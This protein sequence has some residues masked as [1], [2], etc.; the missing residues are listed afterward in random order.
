MRRVNSQLTKRLMAMVGPGGMPLVTA[1]LVL[2]ASLARPSAVHS[3][4][5]VV[6]AISRPEAEQLFVLKLQPL[7]EQRCGSCHGGDLTTQQANLNLLSD[8]GW[9]LGGESGEA[10]I[11][12][13]QPENS[14]ILRVLRW[15][16][17]EMPPKANDRFIPEQIKWFE[18]WIFAGAPW[19]SSERTKEILEMERSLVRTDDGL[20]VETR[21]GQS[22]AW[23]YSRYSEEQLWA[24]R[25]LPID[26]SWNW[27]TCDQHP[28]DLYFEQHD[29]SPSLPRASR[30]TLIRRASF[31]L[32][33]LPPTPAE[34]DE[35][36]NDPA[37]DGTAFET[38][39]DRLLASPHYGEQWGRH[40]LDVTRYAD[41]AGFANDYER[42]NAWRYR[43]YVVRSFNQDKPYDQFI[44][45]QLA[46]DELP[47]PNADA[48]IAVGFLRMG[49]WELTGMEVP[50]IARQRWLDDVTDIVGQVFLGQMLQCA[51][52]HD[53][54]FD[55]ISTRDY[56]SFQ[57]VFAT[58]Q[59]ADRE[60]AFQ[61]HESRIGFDQRRFLEQRQ[62]WYQRLLAELDHR[63]IEAARTWYLEQS[64][65]KEAFEEL[66]AQ[67]LSY[68]SIRNRLMRQ[69]VSTEQI[70]PRHAGFEPRHFG[71]ERV[72]RKGLERLRFSFER[73]E[74]FALSVYSGAT[75]DRSSISTPL[76]LPD[77]LLSG[78]IEQTHVLQGG[79]PFHPTDP[80]EPGFLT[81]AET[82]AAPPHQLIGAG[83]PS[84]DITS[85][86]SGRRLDLAQWIASKENP[87]TARVI[88]NRVW[89][90]HFGRP[91]AP[92][93]NNFGAT[94]GRPDHPELLDQLAI[95]FLNDGW[96]IKQL[97]R[98]IL[99]SDTYQR[100]SRFEGPG[101][102]NASLALPISS[103]SY[104]RFPPRRLEAEEIRDAMLAAS[105]EL[106]RSLGGPPSAPE[107]NPE[108]AYQPRMVM[109][110]FAEAWQPSSTRELRHRRSIYSLK[111][112][113]LLD[114]W[115]ETFDAPSPDLSC[116]RRE[117]SIVTPQ[118]LALLN[119]PQS[120]Q[121]A[122]ALAL[123]V[124]HENES[125]EAVID[126]LCRIL[127]GRIPTA[128]EKT[129]LL[130]HWRTMT[131]RH[132]KLIFKPQEVR[133]SIMRQA[134]EEN[135]GEPF[136][137]EEPLEVV[138]EFEPDAQ[139]SDASPR[140][141]GLAEV[142]LVLFNSNEFLYVD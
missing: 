101:D 107:I 71:L 51:R 2:I 68:D 45:E 138:A 100:A 53:H 36:L 76:R 69:G 94:G 129:L 121:R 30:R 133:H 84:V 19:P 74:P 93:P 125:N 117:A 99:L 8:T 126:S 132:S 39:V 130:D 83:D 105:G 16:D 120:M 34:I 114:P 116:E 31:D 127:L 12:R 139:L 109:G 22:D 24:Y 91:L 111:L 14:L 37:D 108:V 28:I 135:T 66:V 5:S 43:D 54:K 49:P 70:P 27:E 48:L 23:T 55:P 13:E 1:S 89:Q 10:L 122:L 85:E 52:C 110:T 97:H 95:R 11:D 41:S 92:N 102:L 29:D 40:W 75:P 90:W 44:I 58:T 103:H 57:A 56:Y 25:P 131:D 50:R 32:L 81:V 47:N 6:T 141:R 4:D 82:H 86:V 17:L 38:V 128:A 46:G 64:F 98:R 35:F 21:A 65:D 73:Y 7:L 88:V 42:G 124:E 79:D 80:V 87:L 67:N 112:R 96:S 15:E 3:Q 60:V 72:A 62:A 134:V 59:F 20:L 106:N 119:H 9:S 142:A 77:N 113:G 61:T 137:Y 63:S 118:A 78:M 136:E 140:L 115:F 123:K 104:A 18:T 33:G 26:Q